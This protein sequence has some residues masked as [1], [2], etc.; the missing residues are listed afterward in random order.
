MLLYVFR[1]FCF[2]P[3]VH[4]LV[5]VDGLSR[6]GYRHNAPDNFGACIV[7]E[8][9]AR[10]DRGRGIENRFSLSGAVQERAHVFMITMCG[11]IREHQRD[12][13]PAC[14]KR[15]KAGFSLVEALVVIV[16]IVV[17]ASVAIIQI[18][19]ALRTARV[20]TAA[21]YVLNAIR[22]TRERAIDERRKYLMTFA[23]SKTVPF[24]TI[25]VQ[26]GNLNAAGV[27]VFIP[28]PVEP[29]G[30]TLPFDMQFLAPGAVPVSPA[31]AAPPDG[32]CTGAFAID[33]TVTSASGACGSSQTIAFYPDGSITDTSGAPTGLTFGGPSNGVIYISRANEPL[34][35]R[36]VSFFG[37]TGRTKG[38]RLV[39][40]TAT[41]WRWSSMQ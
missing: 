32:L 22:H 7:L 17:I 24:A 20:D 25:T 5:F 15:P 30:L 2:C 1:G 23:V 4:T 19:P 10:P 33:F 28:D 41:T 16:I 6:V 39:P 37:A 18:G 35:M 27:L 31:P 14:S 11:T 40:A 12:R 34:A 21:A 9:K 3:R 13:N 36:A 38:W 29:N 8:F 26:Q